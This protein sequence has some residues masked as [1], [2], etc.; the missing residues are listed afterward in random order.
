MKCPECGVEL[1][2]RN[3]ARYHF[4]ES[5]LSSIYL[6]SICI[7]FCPRHRDVVVPEI[8]HMQE[9]LDVIFG[10]II[11]NPQLLRGEDIRYLRQAIDFTQLEFSKLLG[12]SANTVARWERDE[13]HP[14]VAM[15]LNIRRGVL[16]RAE[17]HILTLVRKRVK[18][19]LQE[20]IKFKADLKKFSMAS[21]HDLQY[22]HP[23][24]P[25]ETVPRALKRKNN[26][27]LVQ[28]EAVAY[29]FR[30]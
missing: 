14:T 10:D 18:Q 24:K 7:N 25:F 23:E 19:L 21:Q 8:P 29:A 16:S 22:L 15:D 12:V 6:G 1:S 26:P 9:L 3:V 4:L 13:L 30:S 5:G 17:E 27:L 20:R 11:L 2:R 28:E